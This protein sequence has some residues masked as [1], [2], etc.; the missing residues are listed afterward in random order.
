MKLQSKA[1]LEVIELSLAGLLRNMRIATTSPVAGSVARNRERLPYL[2]KGSLI[3][4]WTISPRMGLSSRGLCG[5]PVGDV[6]VVGVGLGV[7]VAGVVVVATGVSGGGELLGMQ[8]LSANIQ[9]QT[10][11]V[12]GATLRDMTFLGK[13]CECDA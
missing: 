12:M 5:T 4:S 13:C 10:S 11:T 3:K 9:E 1:P 6:L 7:V 2:L 8:A